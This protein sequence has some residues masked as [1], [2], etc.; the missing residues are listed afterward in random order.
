VLIP[1]KK[2]LGYA[3]GDFFHP[4]HP[5]TLAGGVRQLRVRELG[6]T[7][8]RPRKSATVVTAATPLFFLVFSQKL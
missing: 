5:V 3:L 2:V 7:A 6:Q 8:R 1:T 4:T